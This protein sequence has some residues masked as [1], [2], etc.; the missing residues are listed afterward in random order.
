MLALFAASRGNVSGEA[1]AGVW[2]RLSLPFLLAAFAA[3]STG[4]VCLAARWRAMMVTPDPPPLAP[5][6]VLMVVGTMLH[7]AVPGPVGEMAAAALAAR[8]FKIE[9]EMAFAAGF[10]ARLIGLGVAGVAAVGIYLFGDMPVPAGTDHWLA[11]AT[12]AIAGIV[13]GVIALSLAPAVLERISA[14]V[15]GRFAL[16]RPIHD[17]VVRFVSAM[18]N[19]GRLPTSRYLQAVG[20]AILGH[21][22]VGG[23][24]WIAAIGFGDDPSVAGLAFTYLASTA[25][26]VVMFAFPG[27]Q[28]GW[29]AMFIV[30]LTTTAGVPTADAIALSLVVR[31]QQLVI[32]VL[33]VVGLAVW[34]RDGMGRAAG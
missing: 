15:W 8:R 16:T 23:G 1:V 4:F 33:G 3:L 21:T 25:G 24:I 17:T 11:L 5:L 30:L 28:V 6:T 29:D 10:H 19:I 7:F 26:A 31:L 9:A 20:W 2:K 12:I 14:A 22:C 27:S 18:A 32:V 34:S 13:A